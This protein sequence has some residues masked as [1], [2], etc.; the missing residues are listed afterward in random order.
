MAPRGMER[1]IGGHVIFLT[2]PAAVVNPSEAPIALVL[3]FFL[4]LPK[5]VSAKEKWPSMCKPDNT[6]VRKA[7]ENAMIGVIYEDD[8]Q[9]VDGTDKK[10][11][12]AEGDEPSIRIL[13]WAAGNRNG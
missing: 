8:K 3:W 6:N 13:I 9:I 5:N 1:S 11:F 7:I 12:C 4:S 2:T 10:R